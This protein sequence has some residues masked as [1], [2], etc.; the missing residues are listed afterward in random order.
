MVE[1]KNAAMQSPSRSRSKPENLDR[2]EREISQIKELLNEGDKNQNND[3]SKGSQGKEK[4]KEGQV[5]FY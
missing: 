3:N 5:S 1:S 2:P 4:K